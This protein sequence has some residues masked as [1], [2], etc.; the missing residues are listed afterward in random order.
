MSQVKQNIESL[1][2]RIKLAADRVKRDPKEIQ[3]LAVVKTVE[4]PK[5]FEAIDAG[6]I[7][8]GENKV[9][10]ALTRD[11]EIR[12]KSKNIKIHMIGH[13]QTNKVKQAIDIF[14]VIESVDSY[15][16]AE[17][18]SAKTSNQKEIFVEVNTSSEA[19]KYGVALHELHELVDQISQ[20]KN[21][22][23]TGLMTVGPLS[24]DEKEIR[25]CFRKLREARDELCL[26]GFMDI[27]H[28]SM[29]MSHDFEVAIEEGSDII[30]VGTVIFGGRK[31]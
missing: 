6:I 17:A 5:I 26:K 12:N 19:S 11:K 25:E 28:L 20:L 7:L 22:K 9:Q 13:L 15:H 30:R 10:E 3:I 2:K 14:E 24:G 4:L 1:K 18:I 27:K 8:I 23:I 31:V 21:I 29:G 16:L